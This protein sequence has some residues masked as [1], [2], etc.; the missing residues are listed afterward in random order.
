MTNEK[1]QRRQL[2][3]RQIDNYF[4]ARKNKRYGRDQMAYEVGWVGRVVRGFGE[5]ERREVRI[6]HNYAFLTSVPR[7]REIFATEMEGRRAD[8]ELC[9]A[10]MPYV[11]QELSPRAIWCGT[12]GDSASS[13]GGDTARRTAWTRNTGYD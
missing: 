10:I 12:S 13:A 8:H 2:F 9:D 1:E 11:E 5:R 6:R 4:S 7:W 3:S